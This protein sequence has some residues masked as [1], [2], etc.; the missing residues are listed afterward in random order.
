M[1]VTQTMKDTAYVTVGLGVLGFQ[2]AQVARRELSSTLSTDSTRFQEQLKTQVA[3]VTDAVEAQLADFRTQL[4]RAATN[5]EETLEPVAKQLA[6]RLDE[7]EERLPE[8]VKAVVASA[9]SVAETA[10]AQVRSLLPA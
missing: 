10:A 9:R 2:R 6:G 7:V 5:L 8:Q 3:D 1:D 4:A